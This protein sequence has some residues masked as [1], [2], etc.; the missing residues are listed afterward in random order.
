MR[1]MKESGI[2]WIGKIP[3]NWKI[4]K[5]KDIFVRKNEKANKRLNV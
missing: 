4:G 5:V 1:E 3:E 2:D